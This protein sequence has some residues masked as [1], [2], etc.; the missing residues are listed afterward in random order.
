MDKD[1]SN[2]KTVRFD[3]KKT[4]TVHASDEALNL[5]LNTAR[6]CNVPTVNSRH[7]LCSTDVMLAKYMVSKRPHKFN[8]G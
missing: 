4:D 1:V 5:L 2:D 8:G 6:E 3:Y 7:R